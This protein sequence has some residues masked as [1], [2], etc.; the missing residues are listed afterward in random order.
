MQN[1]GPRPTNPESSEISP[2]DEPIGVHA[3]EDADELD[4]RRL[5]GRP[6]LS[7]FRR[8]LGCWLHLRRHEWHPW[9]LDGPYR[10]K[11][12]RRCSVV[13]WSPQ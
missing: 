4:E 8:Y 12:C 13:W 5:F 3:A 2:N 11:H 9:M 10:W 1:A 7:F 6:P